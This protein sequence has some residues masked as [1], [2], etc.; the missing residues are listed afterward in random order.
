MRRRLWPRKCT[1][2]ATSA[3]PKCE[4]AAGRTGVLAVRAGKGWALGNPAEYGAPVPVLSTPAS[5][6][7]G[8]CG[9]AAEN[10]PTQRAAV[11]KGELAAGCAWVLAVHAGR[12]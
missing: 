9:P 12:G 6:P 3:E 5:Y 8:A 2:T 7:A 1:Y 10:V 11:P 4:P